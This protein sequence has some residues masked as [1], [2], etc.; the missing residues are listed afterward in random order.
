MNVATIGWDTPL[1]DD[2]RDAQDRGQVVI[3]AVAPLAKALA[4]K[5]QHGHLTQHL[6]DGLHCRGPAA[7]G[8]AATYDERN[9]GWIIDCESLVEYASKR[10]GETLSVGDWQREYKLP[11]YWKGEK[12]VDPLRDV[13]VLPDRSFQVAIVPEEAANAITVSLSVRRFSVAAWP[14]AVYGNPVALP[15]ERY[16][17]TAAVLWSGADQWLPPVIEN[18]VIDVREIDRYEIT[19][20]RRPPMALGAAASAPIPEALSQAQPSTT[21]L[22]FAPTS[23]GAEVR[24]RGAP[25]G[26]PGQAAPTPSDVPASPTA[27]VLIEAI[28][29][30]AA[31]RL[32]R[33]NGQRLQLDAR[34]DV[35]TELDPGL[36]RVQVLIGDDIIASADEDFAANTSYRVTVSAQITPALAGLLADS[37]TVPE[38]RTPVPTLQPSES[39]G[40]MQGAIL[41]TL[42]PLLALKPIDQNGL[43]LQSF[44]SNLGIPL[45]PLATDA[46][47]AVAIALDGEWSHQ[48]LQQAMELVTVSAGGEA[49]PIWTDLQGRIALF[50]QASPRLS[51]R[52][53]V[54]VPGVGTID[55]AAPR[56]SGYCATASVTLWPGRP[57]DVSFNLF[58]LPPGADALVKPGRLS[59]A[60]AVAARLYRAGSS[61]D[62]FDYDVFSMMSYG[63]WGDPLLGAMAWLGRWR[64]FGNGE[65]MTP[66]QALQLAGRQSGVHNFLVSAVPLLPDAKVIGALAAPEAER[67]AALDQLI[68][69]P[70]LEQPALAESVAALARRALESGRSDHWSIARYQQLEDAVF[71]VISILEFTEDEK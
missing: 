43:V 4:N 1:P 30:G 52:I 71:N 35:W 13:G 23:R 65:A 51:D 11:K 16:R 5:G 57:P 26:H 48:Q 19:V 55:I 8:A 24:T 44:S 37:G 27:R 33:L 28:D 39:I 22:Q 31:I 2:P 29:P 42:L 9:G 25:G 45:H 60:L 46:P 14:P 36:W 61:L 69:D 53:Q 58:R 32:L 38:S 20:P 49:A 18:P 66:D 3:F 64:R 17:V 15:P 40:P 12:G 21:T 70:S 56:L 34:P 50:L 62:D 54:T 63:S 47:A 6:L 10:I 7:W 59:R 67:H 68:A 41:P